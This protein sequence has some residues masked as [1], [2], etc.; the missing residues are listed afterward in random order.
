MWRGLRKR[1]GTPEQELVHCSQ[2]AFVSMDTS[3]VISLVTSSIHRPYSSLGQSFAP[4]YKSASK[5][6]FGMDADQEAQI[7]DQ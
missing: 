4:T 3:Y 6:N 5:I 7:P 1:A 2:S